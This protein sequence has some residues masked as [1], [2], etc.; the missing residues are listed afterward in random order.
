MLFVVRGKVMR[1]IGLWILFKSF[2][3]PILKYMIRIILLYHLNLAKRLFKI[4]FN[5]T[6]MKHKK[7]SI[8]VTNQ[9][10]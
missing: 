1:L 9:R 6:K 2:L 10:W 4:K 7:K 8:K 5:K 3:G